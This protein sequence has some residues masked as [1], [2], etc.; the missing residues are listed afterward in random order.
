MKSS[1]MKDIGDPLTRFS[2]Y[3]E[4]SQ[5]DPKRAQQSHEPHPRPA[6]VTL[7]T[8]KNAKCPAF[9]ASNS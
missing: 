4:T 5:Q 6:L 1:V 2:V 8:V 9:V 7:C 3:N